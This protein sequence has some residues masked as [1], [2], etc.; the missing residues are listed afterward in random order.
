MPLVNIRNSA[1][2]SSK[3]YFKWISKILHFYSRKKYC[4]CYCYVFSM[5]LQF[6]RKKRKNLIVYAKKSISLCFKEIEKQK[7]CLNVLH[8]TLS[9]LVG[10]F[11]QIS[12][13]LLWQFL[14]FF[15]YDILYVLLSFSFFF[16]EIKTQTHTEKEERKKRKL[17]YYHSYII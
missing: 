4:K 17:Y 15:S 16:Q 2:H 5:C 12:S 8:K 3:V 9:F 1:Q 14:L 10:I 7:K 11:H 13:C 6:H